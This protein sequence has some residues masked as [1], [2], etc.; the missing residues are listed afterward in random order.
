VPRQV[1]PDERRR[2]IVDATWAIITEDGL[3]GLTFR[4]VAERLGGSTTLITHYYGTQ[5]ELLNGVAESLLDS[6]VD[7]L[8]ELEAEHV[9][10]RERLLILLEWLLPLSERGIL[11]ERTRVHLLAEGML[12]GQIRHVFDVWEERIRDLIR[13]HLRGVV[14]NEELEMRVAFLRALT[15]GLILSAIEHPDR[16]PAAEMTS[17]LHQAVEDMGLAPGRGATQAGG[18]VSR[19]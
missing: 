12:E 5:E 3:R 7:A 16:W 18:S 14:P 6:W 13:D 10:P 2:Q 9:D 17:V 4:A 15:N 19:R 8:D 1:D 11:E